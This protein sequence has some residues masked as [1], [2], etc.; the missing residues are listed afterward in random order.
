MKSVH[1]RFIKISE[2]PSLLLFLD[3]KR[4]QQTITQT[5]RSKSRGTMFG[6]AT[7]GGVTSGILVWTH[8]YGNRGTAICL[9]RQRD[10]RFRRGAGRFRAFNVP[11]IARLDES[12]SLVSG[13]KRTKEKKGEGG[14]EGGYL[15]N[16][17]GCAPLLTSVRHAPLLFRRWTRAT[18]RT[19]RVCSL[20][21][22]ADPRLSSVQ[23]NL[24]TPLI[25][26]RTEYWKGAFSILFI[27]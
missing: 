27:F 16:I 13:R 1:T 4:T 17:L 11:T 5:C 20:P 8:K 12:G 25:G 14:K 26:R 21:L 19:D 15:V 18:D 3:S 23:A 7:R 2:I 9:Y 24:L 22:S 10:I 6:T